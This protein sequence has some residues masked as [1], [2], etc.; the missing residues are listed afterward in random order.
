MKITHLNL[1]ND[2]IRREYSK[3]LQSF[4]QQFRYPLGQKKFQIT[5]GRRGDYFTFFDY[6]GKSAMFVIED[7]NKIVATMCGIL[8]FEETNPMWYLADLKIAF[9]YRKHK[10]IE[11]VLNQPI[12]NNEFKNKNIKFCMVNMNHQYNNKFIPKLQ[13][14]FNEYNFKIKDLYFF[15]WSKN[16][17]AKTNLLKGDYCLITNIG[18]KDIIIDDQIIQLY[19]CIHQNHKKYNLNHYDEILFNDLP[20]DAIIMFSTSEI[21]IKDILCSQGN[22][23]D[24]IASYISHGDVIEISSAEI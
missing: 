22:I 10:I 18:I 19:H 5:H 20:E 9:H 13:L 17:F 8:R 11:A 3:R 14:L 23:I 6:L 24:T 7:N 4:E 21:A 15:Q 2:A 12:I 1:T 16:N